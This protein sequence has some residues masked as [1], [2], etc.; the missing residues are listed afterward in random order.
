MFRCK[1]LFKA[2]GLM[3]VFIKIIQQPSE[4]TIRHRDI[5]RRVHMLNVYVVNEGKAGAK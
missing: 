2:A 5:V 4:N 1:E 3:V